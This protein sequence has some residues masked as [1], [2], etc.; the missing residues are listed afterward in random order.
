MDR[1]DRTLR[2]RCAG[3][4][5]DL[6]AHDVAAKT[7]RTHSDGTVPRRRRSTTTPF[8]E[9]WTACARGVAKPVRAAR[10]GTHHR[11]RLRR[12]GRPAQREL[13]V[14]GE[15]P[16][17]DLFDALRR[18]R[19]IEPDRGGGLGALSRVHHP[20]IERTVRHPVPRL[21]RRR[22]PTGARRR[23]VG[24]QHPRAA[25]TAGRRPADARARLQRRPA[26][27]ARSNA[28]RPACPIPTTADGAWPSWSSR[29]AS[30]SSTSRATSAVDA[31]FEQLLA[32]FARHDLESTPPA[33]RVVR[34]DG[35]GWAE[36]VDQGDIHQPGGRRPLLR[37]GRRADVSRPSARRTG[38][39]HGESH[40]V[41]RRTDA[42]RPRAAA[43]AGP[44]LGGGVHG[45][46]DR[47][48]PDA[49]RRVGAADGP[50]EPGADRPRR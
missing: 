32:W 18:S 41:E 28:S 9:L 8:A 35:Y 11:A 3:G 31:A 30:A 24:G 26:T 42:H 19:E 25:R 21:S 47:R 36:C 13:A 14:Y 4:P 6:A 50:L 20:D 49:D 27:S 23:R 5:R 37:T 46:H 16:V 33:P 38:S 17:Y 29:A 15:R 1:V 12:S 39:P 10:F 44:A 7:A 40:R 34:G 48:R 2:R 22:P 43:P 45:R